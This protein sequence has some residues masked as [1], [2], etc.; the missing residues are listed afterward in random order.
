MHKT[1]AYVSLKCNNSCAVSAKPS[2]IQFKP[3]Y[4]K[5]ALIILQSLLYIGRNLIE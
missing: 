5:Y 1:T 3:G 2:E 4:P